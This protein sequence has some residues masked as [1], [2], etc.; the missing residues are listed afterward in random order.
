VVKTDT[1]MILAT[2]K[3]S[4]P[5]EVKLDSSETVLTECRKDIA[6]LL[7]DGLQLRAEL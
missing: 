1:G 6:L 7:V 5:F 3:E 4:E 2:C